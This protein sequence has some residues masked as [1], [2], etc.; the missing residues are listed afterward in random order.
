MWNLELEMWPQGF[1]EWP[2]AHDSSHNLITY[3]AQW[4]SLFFRDQC[5]RNL[6]TLLVHFLF[7]LPMLAIVFHIRLALKKKAEFQNH[8]NSRFSSNSRRYVPLQFRAAQVLTVAVCLVHLGVGSWLYYYNTAGGQPSLQAYFFFFSRSVVWMVFASVLMFESK[9]GSKE[10]WVILRLWW[11]VTFLLSAVS[12]ASAVQTVMTKW[13]HLARWQHADIVVAFVTFPVTVFLFI[14]ALVRSTGILTDNEH[15]SQNN[16]GFLDP[17][18]SQ[19][20]SGLA[21]AH[22]VP[23]LSLSLLQIPSSSLN[24][25]P[26]FL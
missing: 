15:D 22:K 12:F 26:K 21:A 5:T 19:Q 7:L 2:S 4:V 24:V 9:L 10:H 6:F 1:C 25:F 18:L 13:P 14:L 23:S 16:N 3:L 20:D 17:L 8:N 11:I